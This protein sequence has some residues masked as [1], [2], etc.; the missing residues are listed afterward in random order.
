MRDFGGS[1]VFD[2]LFG[3][4]GSGSRRGNRGEDLRVTLKLTLEEITN[5]VEKSIKVKRLVKCGDCSGSGVA[6]GSSKKTCGQCR[7][8][9]QVRRISKTFL[10]TVQQ[11]ATCDGWRGTGEIM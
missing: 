6:A 7:G 2:D 3:M 4:G 9:G 11:I 5:G 10:G 8:A 1:S